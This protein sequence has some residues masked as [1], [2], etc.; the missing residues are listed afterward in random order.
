MATLQEMQWRLH[1]VKNRKTILLHLIEHLDANFRSSGGEKPKSF[2]LTDDRTP[3]T[4]QD[5]EA[6]VTTLLQQASE[7]EVESNRILATPLNAP[8]PPQVP[9][10][11]IWAPQPLAP[12]APTSAP[13]TE[14]PADPPKKGKKNLN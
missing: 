10:H 1:F 8:P 6:V 2:L 5:L 13:A 11:E 9:A 12:P 3:V 7:L 4:D 14:P